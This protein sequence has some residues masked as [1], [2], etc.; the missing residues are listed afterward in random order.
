LHIDLTLEVG[1]FVHLRLSAGECLLR[2]LVVALLERELGSLVPVGREGV[3]L[4]FLFHEAALCGGY[5]GVG[6]TYFDEVGLLGVGGG[7]VC[8]VSEYLLVCMGVERG[9]DIS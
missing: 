8:C 5:F 7:F 6:L 9:L 1:G 2:E 4:F 3:G